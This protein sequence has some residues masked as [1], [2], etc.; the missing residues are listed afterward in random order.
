MYGIA[1]GRTRQWLHELAKENGI[2]YSNFTPPGA[3]TIAQVRERAITFFR[4]LCQEL[5]IKFGTTK[6]HSISIENL[7]QILEDSKPKHSLSTGN[8]HTELTNN[9]IL[10]T[11]YHSS[12]DSALDLSSLS[13]GQQS[14]SS[15]SSILSRNNSFEKQRNFLKNFFHSPYKNHF[16]NLDVLI[17]SHGAVIRELIKYF[18]CDLQTDIGKHFDTIQELAPN[19]SITRFQVT[20]STTKQ[21]IL[22]LIDYHNKTHLIHNEYNLDVINKCSL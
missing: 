22:Q 18:A 10:T 11:S 8:I 1:Q 7:Q 19:T 13:S 14:I 2:P 12:I 9:I 15:S 3:E 20:Y 21:P 16:S 5:L 6:S 4:K 17:I